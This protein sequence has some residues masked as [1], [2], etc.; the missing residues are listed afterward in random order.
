[1]LSRR[2]GSW[3]WAVR[4]RRQA[5]RVCQEGILQDCTVS[6]R[7]VLIVPSAPL[8]VFEKAGIQSGALASAAVGATNVLGTVVAAGLMDKA[9][10]K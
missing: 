4:S 9:G 8:A 1:M 5:G 6:L 3:G 2:R 7:I 10:R